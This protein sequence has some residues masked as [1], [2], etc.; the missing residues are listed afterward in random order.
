MAKVNERRI[1]FN[2]EDFEIIKRLQ[3]EEPFK[4]LQLI[5]MF[6]LG[7]IYGKKEGIRTPLNKKKS[8]RIRQTTIDNSNVLYLMMAIAVEETG[9]FDILANRNDYFKISEEYA[10]TGLTL[11]EEDFIEGPNG[12]LDDLELEALRYL[13]KVGLE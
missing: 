13:D 9:S 12:L 11:L 5:D 4:K 7:I 10:K 6:A 8:G 2:K 3:L 1:N